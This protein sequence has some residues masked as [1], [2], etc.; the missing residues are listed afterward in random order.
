M[1]YWR[2]RKMENASV[3][4]GRIWGHSVLMR[5]RSENI[6]YTGRKVICVGIIRAMST[7]PKHSFLKRNS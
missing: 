1:K 7:R 4:N 3:M 2:S 6:R 5:S